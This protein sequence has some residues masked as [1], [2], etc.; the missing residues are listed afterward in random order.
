MRLKEEN[1][2]AGLKQYN[3]VKFKNKI[4]LK[5]KQKKNLKKKRLWPLAPL[6]HGKQSGK[7]WHQRHI[8]FSWALGSLQILMAPMKSQDNYLWQESYDKPRQCV[9]N[10]RCYSADKGPYSQGYGHPGG[11]VRL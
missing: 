8:S 10:Q 6:L 1:E 9:E 4:K 7:T 3:I 2:R 5:P 11:H